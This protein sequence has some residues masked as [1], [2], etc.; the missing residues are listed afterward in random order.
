MIMEPISNSK[1]G[2]RAKPRDTLHPIGCRFRV[3]KLTRLAM[4]MPIVTKS[5]NRM[6]TAPLCWTGAISDKNKGTASFPN[7]IP[8]PIKTLPMISIHRCSATMHIIQPAMKHSEDTIMVSFL[9]LAEHSFDAKKLETSADRYKD[10]VK[11]C[12]YRL[13]YLQ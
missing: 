7:P 13:S 10:D 5:W 4:R 2:T 11:S 6:L 1:A 8:T 12:K 9:P 3:A